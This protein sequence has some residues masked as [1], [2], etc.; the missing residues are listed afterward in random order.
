MNNR[1]ITVI[2]EKGVIDRVME[3]ARKAGA[4][5][6]TIINGHGT[7]S[8]EDVMYCGVHLV[9]EKEVLLIVAEDSLATNIMKA[10]NDM[11]ELKVKGMGIMFSVPVNDFTV[12]GN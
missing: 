7:A 4:G 9:P 6:G 2:A 10:I 3:T 11:P 5:G 8:M 1:L 12:L